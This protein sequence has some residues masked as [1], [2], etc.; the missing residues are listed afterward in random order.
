MANKLLRKRE[1]QSE[2]RNERDVQRALTRLHNLGLLDADGAG[3]RTLHRLLA[4]FVKQRTEDAEAQGAVEL[5]LI[6]SSTH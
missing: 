5:A 4:A 6:P 2:K 1:K 3:A